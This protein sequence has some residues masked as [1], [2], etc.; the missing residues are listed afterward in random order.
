MMGYYNSLL[1]VLNINLSFQTMKR[2]KHQ[3]KTDYEGE[4]EMD[5]FENPK[6]I[7]CSH[8]MTNIS[9]CVNIRYHLRSRTIFDCEKCEG[10]ALDNNISVVRES[11]ILKTSYSAQT[12]YSVRNIPTED[13]VGRPSTKVDTFTWQQPISKYS[14]HSIND[15][16]EC[17]P[18]IM[19]LPNEVITM[20]FSYLNVCELSTSVAPV[21]K[22]WHVVAHSPALWRK[23]CFD[24]DRISTESAK[25]LLTKSPHLSEL[26]ISNR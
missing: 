9:P 10:H 15:R 20:I 22:H 23:L 18:C 21:C 24:G 25:S 8:K 12:R 19:K 4:E 13:V 11:A 14:K 1:S 7:Y 16:F 6:K 2:T 3:K 5:S 17:E 26:I